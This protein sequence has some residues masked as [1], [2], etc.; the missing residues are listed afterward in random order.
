MTAIDDTVVG[1]NQV[2]SSKEVG[3]WAIQRPFFMIVAAVVQTR[4][5]ARNELAVGPTPDL[6]CLTVD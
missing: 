3:R 2:R 4:I 5:R 1:T 6:C